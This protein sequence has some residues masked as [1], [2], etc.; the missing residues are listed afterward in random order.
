M[1]R[2]MQMFPDYM[3]VVASH[4]T[5]NPNVVQQH[6]QGNTNITTLTKKS[7]ATLGEIADPEITVKLEM[8]DVLKVH[9]E[10]TWHLY[11]LIHRM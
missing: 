7:L 1:I 9:N 10:Q 3:G 6:V 8:L 4:I 2:F 11:H 5:D